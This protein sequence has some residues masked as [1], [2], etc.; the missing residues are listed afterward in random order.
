MAML[1]LSGKAQQKKETTFSIGDKLPDVHFD[2]I[3]NYSHSNAKVS[4]FRGK[5]LILEFWASWCSTCIQMFPKLDSLQR[6]LKSDVQIIL[7]NSNVNDR[8]AKG[9][10]FFRMWMEK[11]NP[12]YSVPSI[13]SDS[14]LKKIL[15]HKYLPHAVI[16]SPDSEILAF[17]SPL[18]LTE[19][20]L[21]VF[22][23]QS[24]PLPK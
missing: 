11:N 1:C 6:S 12:Y 22:I 2:N 20:L 9:E 8:G 19:S 24:Q 4:D 23:Y 18:Q 5:L 14:T 13:M 21:R 3:I 17:V 15:P 10:H 7:V 16:I